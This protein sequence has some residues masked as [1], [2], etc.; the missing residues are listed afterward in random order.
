MSCRTGQ[1]YVAIVFPSLPSLHDEHLVVKANQL[2]LPKYDLLSRD[3]AC[4]DCWIVL[5]KYLQLIKPSLKP[6][7]TVKLTEAL[8]D[9]ARGPLIG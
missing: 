4:R 3:L 1:S 6:L 9:V 8:A 7:G 5:N 2:G